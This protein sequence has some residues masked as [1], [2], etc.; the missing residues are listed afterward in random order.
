MPRKKFVTLG[1]LVLFVIGGGAYWLKDAPLSPGALQLIEQSQGVPTTEGRSAYLY[2]LGLLAPPDVDPIAAGT[3]YLEALKTLSPDQ[4]TSRPSVSGLS[5]PEGELFCNL[6]D[7]ECR[8]TL[9]ARA[10]EIA[11]L[12]KHNATLLARIERFNRFTAFHTASSPDFMEPAINYQALRRGNRLLLLRA[13]SQQHQ[14]NAEAALH[15][16]LENLSSLRAGLAHQDTLLG[17]LIYAK[18]I[19]DSIDIS[20]QLLVFNPG[21]PIPKALPNLS[22]QEKNLVL[23]FAREFAGLL[24]SLQLNQTRSHS[25]FFDITYETW[26]T[27]LLFKPNMTANSGAPIYQYF[28]DLAQLS[29]PELNRALHGPNHPPAQLPTPKFR[30]FVGKV[31]LSVSSPDMTQ[32][33]FTLK[34]LDAKIDLFNQIHVERRPDRQVTN[35]YGSDLPVSAEEGNF[36]L[37][38]P[39]QE[40][41]AK[42]CLPMA[43]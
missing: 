14:G 29:L 37:A 10:A 36:C 18:M 23:P 39:A 30:N 33:V 28:I 11:T 19:N 2:L 41:Q 26:I 21:L 4:R 34:N 42:I 22:V 32:Y 38:T 27:R 24:H 1:A 13:I 8:T 20:A 43:H 9:F 5:L 15:Q 17:K 3:E 7:S 31:L 16:S 6:S 25:S 35:P 40:K 12:L